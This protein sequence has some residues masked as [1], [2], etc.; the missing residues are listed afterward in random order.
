MGIGE[1]QLFPHRKY[2]GNVRDFFCLARRE[3]RRNAPDF[4]MEVSRRVDGMCL[5]GLSWFFFS[6][7]QKRGASQ[8]INFFYA[9]TLRR[10][11]PMV[12]ADG[13]EANGSDTVSATRV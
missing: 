1:V 9:W 10:E 4:F 5:I 12:L 6:A 3:F 8:A 11:W 7:E 13:N 2:N